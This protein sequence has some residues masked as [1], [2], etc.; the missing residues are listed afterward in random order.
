MNCNTVYC[1][2]AIMG[3]DSVVL[4]PNQEIKNIDN[5]GSYR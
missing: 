5:R 3:D 2:N 4:V 1:S